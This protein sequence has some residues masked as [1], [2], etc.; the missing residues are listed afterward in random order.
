MFIHSLLFIWYTHYVLFIRENVKM[1]LV[2]RGRTLN[3]ASKYLYISDLHG[4]TLY[5]ILR[6]DVTTHIKAFRTPIICTYWCLVFNGIPQCLVIPF[7]HRPHPPPPLVF[8]LS[9]PNKSPWFQS[10]NFTTTAL[11]PALP[12]SA[13][14]PGKGLWWA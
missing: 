11:S 12:A 13:P 1:P 14:P 4:P 6:G 8:P 10:P 3:M 7:R 9:P 2:L 5:S